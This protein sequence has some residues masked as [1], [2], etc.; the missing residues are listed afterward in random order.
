LNCKQIKEL[1]PSYLDNEL[2]IKKHR[3]VEKHINACQICKKETVLHARTWNLLKKWED[4]EPN[5]NYIS[6]FWA[7]V[8][9]RKPWQEKLFESI[10]SIIGIISK[11]SLI[12]VLVTWGI[13]I[14]V[15]FIAATTYLK[16]Q[17]AVKLLTNLSP[18]E[19]EMIEYIDL[20]D[21]FEIVQ[22]LEFFE[23]LEIINDLDEFEA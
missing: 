2:D 4:I 3:A 6:R 5:P 19:L 14:M 16:K 11:N 23:D 10:K 18:N 21:N 12:P 15:G 7:E 1:I 13:V 20:A 17:D 9:Y 22:N 8:A